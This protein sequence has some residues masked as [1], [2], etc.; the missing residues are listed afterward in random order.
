M[1]DPNAS[2]P[3]VWEY[4]WNDPLPFDV[5][6]IPDDSQ[7]QLKE[8]G[9]LGF[10]DNF[11]EVNRSLYPEKD[12]TVRQSPGMLVECT[13]C[14]TIGR[15]ARRLSPDLR[16]RVIDVDQVGDSVSIRR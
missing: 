8:P 11:R 10:V 7:Q 16:T 14:T 15:H 1:P 13:S 9:A 12:P 5:A 4:L 2:D 3:V 6:K